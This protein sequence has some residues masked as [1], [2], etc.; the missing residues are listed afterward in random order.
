MSEC[1]KKRTLV[2]DG[3]EQMTF[4]FGLGAVDSFYIV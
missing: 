4:H 1:A 2:N 3:T